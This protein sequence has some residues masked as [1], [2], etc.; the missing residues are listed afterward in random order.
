MTWNL[1]YQGDHKRF[2][3]LFNFVSFFFINIGEL[4]TFFCTDRKD[5]VVK[6]TLITKK[7]EVLE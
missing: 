5:V 6:G 2:F 4:A 1:E 3:A 7:K